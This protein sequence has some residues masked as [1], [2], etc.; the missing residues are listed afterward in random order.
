MGILLT[1]VHKKTIN[2][3]SAGGRVDAVESV[4]L[5]SGHPCSSLFVSA[6]YAG[7]EQDE[8]RRHRGELESV[9]H[10]SVLPGSLSKTELLF[11]LSRGG[12]HCA[13]QSRPKETMDAGCDMGLGWVT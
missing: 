11:P 1:A 3:G 2:E 8:L 5:P 7:C 10:T 12:R 6:T 9:L 13:T 4:C